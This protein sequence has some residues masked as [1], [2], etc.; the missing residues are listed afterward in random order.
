MTKLN[1]IIA[2][3]KDVKSQGVSALAGGYK[4]L[5]KTPLL[6]G[7]ARTYTPK[8]DD[9]DHLPSESTRV[10]VRTED[11][12]KQVQARLTRMFDVVATK[13][14]TN[15]VARADVTVDGETLL[16]NMPVTVL[17]FLEKQLVDLAAFVKSLPVLDPAETW[18]MDDATNSYATPSVKTTRTKKIPR[19]HVKAEATDRHP[20][21]VDVYTEDVL[22]GTWTTVKYSGAITDRRST[23]LQER[24][25]TLHLAV[26]RAREEAN[27]TDVQ[28]L[29]IGQKVLGY[30]L[31][32]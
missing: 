9:G 29:A 2:I 3:E 11:V 22:V 20:A 17:L 4:T 5:Q 24:I 28:D 12:L 27:S 30:L 16:F 18:H 1:Q 13:E 19:N 7:I 26:K 15:M 23:E 25:E 14:N 32:E 21:Q 6:S 31:A 8:D 10:Q